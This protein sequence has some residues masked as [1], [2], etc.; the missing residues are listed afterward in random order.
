MRILFIGA[1]SFYALALRE[2]I[3]IQVEVIAV[4]IPKRSA[5]AV[6]F[7]RERF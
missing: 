6:V 2:P 1:G 4:C 5:E 7:V 3:A